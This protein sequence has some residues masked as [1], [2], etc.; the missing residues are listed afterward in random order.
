MNSIVV[1][2]LGI[3]APNGIGFN[4]FWEASVNG[5][6]S[7]AP[8]KNLNAESFPDSLAGEVSN[9]ALASSLKDAKTAKLTRSARMLIGASEL[10]IQ[11]AELSITDDNCHRVGMVTG[12]CF[13][14]LFSMYEF[15]KEVSIEGMAFAEP[16]YFTSTVLSEPSSQVSIQ[17]NIQGFNTTVSSSRTSALSA[18]EYAFNAIQAGIVDIVVCASIE[19]LSYPLYKGLHYLGLLSNTQSGKKINLFNQDSDDFVPGEAS[20]VFI[21]ESITSAVNRGA[22]IYAKL[23]G[24]NTRYSPSA[25]CV[26]NDIGKGLQNT[27]QSCLTSSGMD[28]EQVDYICSSANS[29][30]AVD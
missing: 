29:S 23:D 22:R 9:E 25:L 10:A 19:A 26:S 8:I 2:G 21:V 1:T 12:T 4:N 6:I 14:H 11:N 17:N 16:F 7:I 3:I 28:V 20:C 27:I 24:I 18:I 15:D 5:K 13:S 30:K